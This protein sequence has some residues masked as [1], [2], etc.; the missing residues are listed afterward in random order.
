MSTFDLKRNRKEIIIIILGILFISFNLRAPL[1]AVGSIVDLIKNEYTLNNTVAGFITTIPLIAFALISP[2][3]AKIANKIGQAKV[4][5][6]GLLLIFVSGLFRSYLGPIGL[7]LG[8][9]LIGTGIAI[10]NVVIPGLIKHHFTNKVGIITSIYVTGMCVFAALGAGVSIPLATE[11]QLGWHHTLAVWVVLALFTILIWAPQVFK[12]QVPAQVAAQAAGVEKTTSVWTD[13]LAWG[14]T[15][16]MGIQSLIF[17]SL[18]AWLPTIVLS[19]DFSSTFASSMAFLFQI[20]A[21]PATLVVP[22]LC[23][24]FKDQRILVVVTTVIYGIGIGL[25]LIGTTSTII[26]IATILMAIGMGG[27]I[28]LSIAFIALRSPDKAKAAELSGMSQSAGYLFAALGPILLG[29]IYDLTNSWTLPIVIFL[30][31]LVLLTLIGIYAGKN[32][33]IKQ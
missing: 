2:F 1:T 20:M 14:V 27:S 7:F 6:F 26:T 30:V 15:F 24:K 25:F 31:L 32:I 10:G 23:D 13:K 29:L 9:A 18:V 5:M 21:I 19:K 16:F 8:T 11:F 33:T 22:T 17:Y 12:K 28:S 3:V 4:M